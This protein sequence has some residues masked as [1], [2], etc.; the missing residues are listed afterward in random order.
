[1]TSDPPR[2]SFIIPARDEEL[3]IEST[4][5]SIQRAVEDCGASFEITVVDD[6]SVDRT[7]EIAQGCGARIVSVELRNIGAVRNAGAKV[8]NGDL[9]IF[10]DADTL[11]SSDTLSAILKA[12]DDGATGG[13]AMVRFD[14]GMTWLQKILSFIFITC[15][16]RLFGW[17]AGCCM[18]ATKQAFE[19]IHGFNE[20]HYAAEERYF[21]TALKRR[22]KFVIVQPPVI[23]SARKLRI[24]STWYLIRVAFSTLLFR[25]TKRQKGLEILYDAPRESLTQRDS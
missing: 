9:L 18:Y 6:G 5:Q 22:G 16:Q 13:G 25:G 23:S 19:D 1:M 8:A 21:S 12:V 24:F 10:L 2:I 11:I 3:L 7:A 17:A 4:I 14:S 20:E 15:W